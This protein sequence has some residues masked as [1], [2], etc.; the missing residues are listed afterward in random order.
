MMASEKNEHPARK[1]GW[2]PSWSPFAF[3]E[4]GFSLQPETPNLK[5]ET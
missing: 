2:R 5:L 3:R 4:T 1:L